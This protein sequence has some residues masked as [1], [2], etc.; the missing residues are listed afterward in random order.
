MK[1][2]LFDALAEYPGTLIIVSHEL[3]FINKLKL[4]QIKF[5]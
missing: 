1:K 3:E 2:A 4:K 5:Q